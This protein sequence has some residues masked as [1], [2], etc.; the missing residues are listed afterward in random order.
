MKNAKRALLILLIT[1]APLLAV[2]NSQPASLGGRFGIWLL[3]DDSLT[4]DVVDAGM[5]YMIKQ[6]RWEQIEPAQDLFG[7]QNVDEW[8]EAVLDPHDLTGVLIIRTGQCWATDNSYDPELG[9][10]IDELASTPPLDYG[11]YY[12]LIYALVGH[13]KG[14]IEIF[15]I[16]NDPITLKSWYG[17]PEE[18]VQLC[19]VAYQAAKDANPRCVVIAN[20]VPAMSFGYLIARDLYEGGRFQDAIDFWNGYYGR[21]DEQF[22]VDSLGE[23][24]NWLNSDFG[25]WTEH[26]AE[27]MMTPEQAQHLDAIGF[28]YYLHYDYIDDVV[29]WLKAKME[30]KGFYRPLLDLEHGV[31]DERLVVSDFVASEE[32]V[33]AYAILQAEGIRNLSWYPF[34]IDTSSHNVEYLKPMYDFQTSEF[35]PP[36]YA[37]KTLSEYFEEYHTFESVEAPSFTRYSFRNLLT[38]RVD[39]EIIW[40]E[41]GDMT[42]TLP[43][44]SF[45]QLATVSDHLGISV[46][47]VRNETGTLEI[48]VGVAPTFIRWE[49]SEVEKH[50][51]P[52]ID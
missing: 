13:L 10:E 47:S 20:K 40:N 52:Q 15:I 28:N 38:E 25:L 6:Y 22:Q 51:S 14:R 50:P 7:F 5:S 34:T 36:Y 33:K 39:L 26:F 18:Y 9:E 29:Q 3:G 31:K 2:V 8:Y 17:T 49:S 43:F 4:D 19:G 12:D 46:D 23:L 35:L 41:A 42:L 45:S 16:E 11:D 32:L 30:E 48:E 1:S 37:M 44:P 24:L 27:V 21:R